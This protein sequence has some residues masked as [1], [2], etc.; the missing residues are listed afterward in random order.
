MTSSPLHVLP[1]PEAVASAAAEA[2]ERICHSTIKE[3]GVCNVAVSGGT[4]PLLFFK[5]LVA[6]H[7]KTLD[8][9][10]V[11]W[12]WVD[13]RCVPPDDPESNY[14]AA[15][16][17]LLVPL[18]VPAE[19]V[20]RIKGE[21]GPEAAAA[22]YRQ[23]LRSNLKHKADF[24]HFDLIVLGVGEDG[25]TASLFPGGAELESG[26]VVVKSVSP[27][28]VERVSLSLPVLNAAKHVIFLATGAS[29]SNILLRV[30]EGADPEVPASLVAP[31][32]P[33]K[34]FVDE[35]AARGFSGGGKS[36]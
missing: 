7:S 3:H 12:F 22:D 16:R 29:K 4:T 1:D 20:H 21:L 15:L 17:V 34:W 18:N 28:G 9:G 27:D 31:A 19:N 11:H 35:A 6:D 10:K 30:L 33:P 23:E 32:L 14:G 36:G 25:H 8:W 13:E 24:P 2:L 26:E 5:R